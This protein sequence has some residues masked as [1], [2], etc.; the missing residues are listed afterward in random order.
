VLRF[1][2]ARTVR[3]SDPAAG[4]EQAVSVVRYL[5]VSRLGDR[6][7]GDE[8]FHSPELQMEAIDREFDSVFGPGRWELAAVEGSYGQATFADF[9]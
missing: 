8:A 9:T 1:G 2:V 5:R 4:T 6:I 7:L 3:R